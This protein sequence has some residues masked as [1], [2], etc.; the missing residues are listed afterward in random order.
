[1]LRSSTSLSLYRLETRS[2]I[3]LALGAYLGAYLRI[4][5][6][7]H[8]IS[9]FRFLLGYIF[10]FWAVAPN[11]STL[12]LILFERRLLS[13]S[14][15]MS[16]SDF[17]ASV[18]SGTGI[19]F[20]FPFFLF[21]RISAALGRFSLLFKRWLKRL[22]IVWALPGALHCSW[23]SQE[24][25]TALVESWEHSMTRCSAVGGLCSGTSWKEPN[26]DKQPSN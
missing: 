26:K 13:S 8:F 25:R 23:I 10:D 9:S 11:Y 22:F 12:R 20:L 14:A 19:L 5:D 7:C 4:C 24:G 3:S 6:Y 16:I 15:C 2:E 1:M 18:M 21:Y 17:D